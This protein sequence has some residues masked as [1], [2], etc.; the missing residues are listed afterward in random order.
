MRSVNILS[1]EGA[2]A[3]I[4]ALRDRV[5]DFG[6]ETGRHTKDSDP[7]NG[8]RFTPIGSREELAPIANQILLN[9]S[10][11]AVVALE[12]AIG[13]MRDLA[14]YQQT[15]DAKRQKTLSEYAYAIHTAQII[16]AHAK[17][18]LKDHNQ[19]RDD[20]GNFSRA[21]VLGGEK[22]EC[23]DFAGAYE[24]I[25]D[26]LQSHL[27]KS[28]DNDVIELLKTAL[29]LENIPGIN[30][31]NKLATLPG[32]Y[33]RSFL[34]LV[35]VH[36][37]LAVKGNN[38]ARLQTLLAL[39]QKGSMDAANAFCLYSHGL[40]WGINQS[41]YG[42]NLLINAFAENPSILSEEQSKPI[43]GFAGSASAVM[44]P[45]KAFWAHWPKPAR[46]PR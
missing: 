12:D 14:F 37:A 11:G 4:K 33:G 20:L 31:I 40:L 44:V 9:H 26:H 39:T 10:K 7:S 46:S 5:K 24:K 42:Q 15:L 13:T 43:A 35:G 38:L 22:Y 8:W 1:H 3:P 16:D 34:N 18:T 17:N 29:D 23:I 36:I 28:S 32:L 2:A 6:F 41:S 30:P 25:G 27:G 45:C 19:Y 21:G